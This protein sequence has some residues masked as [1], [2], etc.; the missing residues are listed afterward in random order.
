MY[1]TDDDDMLNIPYAFANKYKCLTYK[2]LKAI[3]NKIFDKQEMQK[4]TD[5]Q[6]FIVQGFLAAV[7]DLAKERDDSIEVEMIRR[8]IERH[9]KLQKLKNK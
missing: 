9:D 5:N 4:L 1:E 2:R 6:K 3:F 8:F 7:S